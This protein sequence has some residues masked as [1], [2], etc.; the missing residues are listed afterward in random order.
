[1]WHLFLDLIYIQFDCDLHYL[2]VLGVFFVRIVE[3]KKI[4][5]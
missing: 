1:M 3:L 4:F 2:N 5:H